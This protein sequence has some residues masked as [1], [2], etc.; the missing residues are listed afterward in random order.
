M[1]HKHGIRISCFSLSSLLLAVFVALFA[2]LVLPII[3]LAPPPPRVQGC[4]SN[5]KQLACG[6]S[7][8]LQDYDTRLPPSGREGDGVPLLLHPYVK[9]AEVWRC[10]SDA[11]REAMFDGRNN[12]AS[13]NYGYNWLGL[14]RE[15]LPVTLGEVRKPAST[16]AFAESTGSRA[17]PE[18]LL[19][20]GGAGPVYRHPRND[21]DG[22]VGMN[23]AW[24]DGHVT[25]M[26]RREVEQRGA[27]ESDR[28][29]GSGIDV[30]RYW[31][32]R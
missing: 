2:V 19:W 10:R 3:L 24:L 15:G 5:E 28:I 9:N 22:P 1:N 16:L 30:Y 20:L 11:R 13:V 21:R 6:L 23:V 14:T 27:P 26:A 25:W 29:S 4:A 17:T 32:R 8:Y 12:D 31:N 7:M 18:R